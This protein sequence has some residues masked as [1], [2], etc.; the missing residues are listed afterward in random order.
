MTAL[1]RFRKTDFTEDLKK[2]DIPVLVMHG[3]EIRLCRSAPPAS[4]REDSEE[5]TLKVY[6][7][8]PHGMPTTTRTRSTPTARVRTAQKSTSA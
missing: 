7:G 5:R 2:I 1:R 3:D 4:C 8:Y 6:P